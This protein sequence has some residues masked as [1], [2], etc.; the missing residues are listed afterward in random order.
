MLA[1]AQRRTVLCS[2]GSLCSHLELTDL[3][4]RETAIVV[5]RVLLLLLLG[6]GRLLLGG[7][8]QIG[9]FAMAREIDASRSRGNLALG[10]KEPRL[11]VDDVV[12]QLVVFGLQRLV[13]L[14]ELL[15]LLDLV[16]E[17]LDVFLFALAKGSLLGKV[18]RA[19]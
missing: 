2:C 13:K 7:L 18:S 9:G 11:Q 5:V 12:A 4:F 8:V 10:L 16:L 19:L 3:A 1:I 17:L 14:A 6:F 15:E